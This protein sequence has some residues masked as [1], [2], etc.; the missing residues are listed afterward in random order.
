MA[1]DVVDYGYDFLSVVIHARNRDATG[2]LIARE[3]PY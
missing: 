2:H 3:T 1:D